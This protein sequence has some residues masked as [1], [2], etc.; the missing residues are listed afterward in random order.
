M[1]LEDVVVLNAVGGSSRHAAAESLHALLCLHPPHLPLHHHAP[2]HH[3]A[4]QPQHH[5]QGKR[6]H[7]N[8]KRSF[9]KL[10]AQDIRPDIPPFLHTV[11]ILSKPVFVWTLKF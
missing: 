2:L 4:P 8:C 6:N 3:Q 10:D 7:V 9:Y 5:R 1:M 11:S